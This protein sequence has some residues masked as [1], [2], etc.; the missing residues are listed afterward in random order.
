MYT[1]TTKLAT[2]AGSP[3]LEKLQSLNPRQGLLSCSLSIR[4][5]LPFFRLLNFRFLCSPAFR[6]PDF[7][8]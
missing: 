3:R 1:M 5:F 8:S 6:L 4:R 2:P 7:V